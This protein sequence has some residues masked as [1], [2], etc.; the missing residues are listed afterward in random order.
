M[1]L[2]SRVVAKGQG[3]WWAA[4]ADNLFV[5][6]TSATL[7]LVAPVRSLLSQLAEAVR[8][9]LAAAA[10][11]PVLVRVSAFTPYGNEHRRRTWT[12]ASPY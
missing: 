2:P 6:F 9:A 11:A 10:P 8:C 5:S 7:A 3:N 4:A 1:A 12:A